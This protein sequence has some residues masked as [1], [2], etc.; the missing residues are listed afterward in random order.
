MESG[1][2]KTGKT[3]TTKKTKSKRK[4]L[5]PKSQQQEPAQRMVYIPVR[6]AG[7]RVTEET[8]LTLGAFW[9]CVRYISE[10]IAMLP[11]NEFIRNPGG[12]A[13]RAEGSNVD[14]LIHYQ[15][16]PE[17]PALYW[18]EA[19]VAHA[20]VWGNS[21]SEI[22][23]DLAGR[24]LWLWQIAPDRVTPYRE[25]DGSLF[26]EVWNPNGAP[27]SYIP[28]ADMF[29]LRGPTFDG[30][31]GYNLAKLA[32]RCIGGGIALEESAANYFANDSTPGGILKSPHRLD[33]EARKNLRDSWMARHAGPRNRRMI[34]VL[35]Q[36]LEWVQ[37]TTDPRDSQM[38]EQRAMTPA[39]VCRWF[40]VP[41]HKIGD[42]A[43]ATFSNIEQQAIEA[44]TDCLM[45]W[46]CRF[47]QE[48]NMKLFGR[49]NRGTHFV[50]LNFNALLRGDTQSRAT[51]YQQLLDRGIFDINE[52]RGLEDLNPIGPDGDKRF[53]QSNMQL[54]EKAGEEP[55]P[56]AAP[57][58]QQDGPPAEP[59]SDEEPP[60][61][62]PDQMRA[63]LAPII[64]DAC[65]RI[66]GREMS[67]L[68]DA[69][70]RMPDN[71]EKIREWH[72]DFLKS[73]HEYVCKT[74]SPI[75]AT[76]HEGENLLDTFYGVY[77]ND[78]TIRQGRIATGTEIDWEP[79]G[80]Q[81]ARWLME[82]YVAQGG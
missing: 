55:P 23:R 17:T 1:V 39:E 69:A 49:T 48:A 72:R 16:N 63:M 43:R 6:Q 74:L 45:P 40:R 2:K 38:Q 36:G 56:G 70:K 20:C 7:V 68:M 29:H 57:A 65:R 14:W 62:Q 26:Y 10:S 41:P 19:M 79:L 51:F 3:T 50:K 64:A 80:D 47:E 73:Q 67:C 27:P 34:A 25:M 61:D 30:I 42:L 60:A 75:L 78:A 46:G 8:A 35:E 9:A 44:V 13:R 77:C 18:R 21:Y 5:A 33:E 24:P 76:W 71:V 82:K 58:Q 28:A 12:G 32:A 15:A 52:V 53:V 22:E 37:S 4:Q 11:C 59:D 81:Y 66:V 54:L 31:V